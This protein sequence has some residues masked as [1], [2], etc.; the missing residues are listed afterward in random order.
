WIQCPAASPPAPLRSRTGLRVQPYGRREACRC[1][2]GLSTGLKKNTPPIMYERRNHAP[3]R[4]AVTNQPINSQHR[5][6]QHDSTL[7]MP[8][9]RS[10]TEPT[11]PAHQLSTKHAYDFIYSSW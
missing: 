3:E 4:R 1:S 10:K 11:R 7:E 8:D 9:I 5:R 2:F 6:Q